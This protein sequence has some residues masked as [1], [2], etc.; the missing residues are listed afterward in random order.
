MV[1]FYGMP[2]FVM[3]SSVMG[4]DETTASRRSRHEL[5]LRGRSRPVVAAR[6]LRRLALVFD[7]ITAT[8]LGGDTAAAGADGPVFEGA[9]RR[10]DPARAGS[11]GIHDNPDAVS[12]CHPAARPEEL[13]RDGVF[14]SLAAVP[15]PTGAR[16]AS[17][18]PL[19]TAAV[20]DPAGSGPDQGLWRSMG[21]SVPD[22]DVPAWT[23]V[24]GSDPQER[25]A[26]AGAAAS[27]AGHRRSRFRGSGGRCWIEVCREISA[28]QSS[29]VFSPLMHDLL[30]CV[31]G[32]A[33]RKESSCREE[34]EVGTLAEE[35]ARRPSWMGLAE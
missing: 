12:L 8:L 35:A 26:A 21:E 28:S 11:R 19:D 13:Y 4:T 32:Q 18:L 16:L 14:S 33:A 24:R 22:G 20:C 27:G 30:P 15:P 10:Q 6:P 3:P 1:P 31:G 17:L 7:P 9:G 25:V 2:S 29:I 34:D 23:R 5:R